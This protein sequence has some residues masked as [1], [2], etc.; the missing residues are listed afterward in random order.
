MAE[1]E[2]FALTPGSPTRQQT[3]DAET[4]LGIF[5]TLYNFE[6]VLLLSG[7]CQ[8]YIRER[9][10]SY[11]LLILFLVLSVL[12][13]SQTLIVSADIHEPKCEY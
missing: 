6:E 13:G 12:D 4:T 9:R 5:N 10:Q 3:T 7:L 2:H 11:T 1:F 8:H